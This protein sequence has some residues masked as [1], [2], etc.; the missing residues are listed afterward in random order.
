MPDTCTADS[1][2]RVADTAIAP[3]ERVKILLQ[4][5]GMRN[6]NKYTG[7]LQTMSVVARE[8]G[9][10]KL[11]KGNGANISRVVPNV[12]LKFMFNDKVSAARRVAAT[13]AHMRRAD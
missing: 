9:V 5:Q 12:S 6:S 8:E 2:R 11:W 3:L 1:A 7:V 13:R 4:I 10:L